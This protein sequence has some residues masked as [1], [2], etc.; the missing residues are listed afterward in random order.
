[1]TLDIIDSNVM[2]GQSLVEV[3][4]ERSQQEYLGSWLASDDKS[5]MKRLEQSHTTQKKLSTSPSQPADAGDSIL[6]TLSQ[7]ARRRASSTRE[8]DF[9]YAEA[10]H[11]LK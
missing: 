6:P 3:Q 1:M 5:A 9:L 11:S 7:P 8:S 4:G 10:L 2:P